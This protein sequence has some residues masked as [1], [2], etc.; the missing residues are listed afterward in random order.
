MFGLHPLEKAIRD[1]IAAKIA[2]AKEKHDVEIAQ[3]ETDHEAKV[4][5]TLARLEADHESQKAEILDAAVKS[6]I[7]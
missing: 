5:A 1:A 6:V 7:G 3:A 4:D 2:K